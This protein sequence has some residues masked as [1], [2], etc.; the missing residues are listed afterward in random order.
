M[1][2]LRCQ[3]RLTLVQIQRNLCYATQDVRDAYKL[4]KE[5]LLAPSCEKVVF[6]LHSQGG[7]EGGLI[8]DWLLAELPHDVMHRLEVYTFGNAA[9][10]FNNPH[11]TAGDKQAAKQ[12]GYSEPDS[13]SI[14]YIEHYANS[15]DFVSRFGVLH[16]AH[17]RN[18]FMGRV[19]VALNNGH[20]L[21]QHYLHDMFPLDGKHQRALDTSRF[22]EMNIGFSSD[23]DQHVEREGPVSS[24]LCSSGLAED[25]DGLVTD[26]NSPIEKSPKKKVKD[27]SRLW[28]Y[29]NGASPSDTRRAPK[30]FHL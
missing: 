17:E 22:M 5:A 3:Q 24:F 7:I 6:I 26:V 23:G 1:G 12:K 18:A 25:V 19:F 2:Y 13:K 30:F 16:Y 8:I 15:G 27:F 10:H 29:R 9:N 11:K 21:N 20:L 14:G 4:I 28:Q